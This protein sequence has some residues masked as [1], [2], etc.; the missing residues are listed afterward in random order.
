MKQARIISKPDVP[1]NVKRQAELRSL[2][3]QLDRQW[4]KLPPYVRN[5]DRDGE[6]EEE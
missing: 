1:A 5:R 3:A 4:A 6:K 2:A